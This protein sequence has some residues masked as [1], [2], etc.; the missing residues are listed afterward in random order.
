MSTAPG[1]SDISVVVV[2]YRKP[3]ALAGLLESLDETAA[4]VVVVN[5]TDDPTVTR[6]AEERGAVIVPLVDNLGYAA[7]VNTGARVATGEVIV[8][9]NDDVRFTAGCLTR[10]ASAVSSGTGDV[11]VPQVVDESSRPIRTVQAVPSLGALAREWLLLPDD[12]VP[13]L[14]KHLS[15]EKWR[16]PPATE[17]IDA[18]SAVTVAVRRA[19]LLEQP[20]PE[21]YFLYWEESEWFAKLGRAGYSVIYEP[22]AAVIHEGGRAVISPEKSALLARNA[23][24]CIRRLHGS[25]HARLAFPLVVAWQLRLVSTALARALVPGGLGARRE[26][27]AARFAGLRAALSAWSETR[28]GGPTAA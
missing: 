22:S 11:V 2:A 24:R 25:R 13:S 17:R 28:E 18:A 4:E 23:V 1:R 10:L 9:T 20:M 19:L 21:H 26:L 7:A 14:A 15:V 8:F 3:D 6:V 27:L 16:L 12:P 5:V